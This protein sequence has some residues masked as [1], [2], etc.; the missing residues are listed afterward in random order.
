MEG[1]YVD[2]LELL[3]E[4]D[5]EHDDDSDDSRSDGQ[6]G[7]GQLSDDEIQS[8][9]DVEAVFAE[10]KTIT[11]EILSALGGLEESEGEQGLEMH[12]VVGDDCLRE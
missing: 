11:V 9:E 10:L 8:P 12:Y 6:R 4:Y 1:G 5:L 2:D 3:E 7:A